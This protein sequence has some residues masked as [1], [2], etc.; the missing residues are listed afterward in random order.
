MRSPSF[1]NKPSQRTINNVLRPEKQKFQHVHTRHPYQKMEAFGRRFLRHLRDQRSFHQYLHFIGSDSDDFLHRGP[2]GQLTFWEL[3]DN[4]NIPCRIASCPLVSLTGEPLYINKVVWKVRCK[5]KFKTFQ[6][7]Q[8]RL[9]PENQLQQAFALLD[10]GIYE[11]E[12]YQKGQSTITI[13][14]YPLL[15]CR[16]PKVCL[17]LPAHN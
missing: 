4:Q 6:R 2:N 1:R 12:Q 17:F 10:I 11:L 9:S 5:K 16:D 14:D 8:K 13:E 7:V 3:R 15:P